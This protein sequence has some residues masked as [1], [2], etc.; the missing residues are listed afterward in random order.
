M[1]EDQ[2]HFVEEFGLAL[3]R[4]GLPWMVGQVWGYLLISDPPHQSAEELAKALQASRGSMSTTTRSLMQMGLIDKVSFP[5]SG[6]TTSASGRVCGWTSSNSG[7]RS[8]RIGASSRS[9]A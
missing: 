4:V 8:S 6:G 3:E 5:A 9:E 2:Q 7:R 1:D